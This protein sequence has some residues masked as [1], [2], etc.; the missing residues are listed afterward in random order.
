MTRYLVASSRTMIY[1]SKFKSLKELCLEKIYRIGPARISFV[2]IPP[3][4]VNLIL[5]NI[6]SPKDL[7][8]IQDSE[9]N[10]NSLEFAEAIDQRWK[11][12][13]IEKFFVGKKPPK[14]DKNVTW[15]LMYN[16]LERKRKE[17]IERDMMKNQESRGKNKKKSK[18]LDP[19]TA[20][21]ALRISQSASVSRSS[22]GGHR[23]SS[24]S[25]PKIGKLGRDF[26]KQI[27]RYG[28]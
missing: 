5:K 18:I 23:S 21:K 3:H 25:T 9:V 1:T 15:R 28:R 13:V 27:S 17:S 7:A 24:A 14:L 4:L 22:Y 16:D 8:K 26:L 11:Q 10:K 12:F 2:G 19:K 6:N 20:E